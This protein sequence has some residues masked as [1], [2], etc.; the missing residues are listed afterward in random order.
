M[1]DFDDTRLRAAMR[2][3]IDA[4]DALDEAVVAGTVG[5]GSREVIDR[6]DKKTLAEMTLRR[7]LETHGWIA[8]REAAPA[9]D[10]GD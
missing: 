9:A 10:N 7:Q 6:A 8:P 2:A 3:F 1:T 5:D 4:A